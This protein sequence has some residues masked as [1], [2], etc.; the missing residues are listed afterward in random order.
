MSNQLDPNFRKKVILEAQAKLTG[1]EYPD[2]ELHIRAWTD[3]V[4]REYEANTHLRTGQHLYCMLPK[5]FREELNGTLHD[6]FYA[7]LHK[8]EIIHWFQRHIIFDSEGRPA[9]LR[10]Y[11]RALWGRQNWSE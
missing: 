3:R 7:N 9:I 10:D 5:E 8:G 6:P 2:Q 4:M 11:E 1:Y